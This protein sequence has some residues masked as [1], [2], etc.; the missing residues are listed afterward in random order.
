MKSAKPVVRRMLRFPADVLA[1]SSTSLKNLMQEHAYLP[2]RFFPHE[3]DSASYMITPSSDTD[4]ERSTDGLPI[5]PKN[6]WLGLYRETNEYFLHSGNVH[7]TKML[8]CLKSCGHG[9]QDGQRILELGCRSGRMIRWLFQYAT[10]GEIWGADISAD[11]ILW[12]QQYLSPPF[13]FV[14][15]TTAPHLP[16]EDNYFDL[17][18]CGSVFTHIADLAD[19]WLLELRRIVKSG[20]HLYI[21]VHDK[22]TAALIMNDPQ[23]IYDTGAT[24]N[25]W[26]RNLLL[27]FDKEQHFVGKNYNMFTI[28]RGPDSQVFYDVDYLRRHWG[29]MMKV[30][31]VKQEAFG[32][33][34]A[35]VLQK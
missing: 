13:H 35:L 23:K 31:T 32:Y 6:L 2:G 12:C 11:H 1:A 15:V 33:Q 14:T 7:V 28:S 26:T 9:V 29:G 21:T 30:L 4:V 22:H 5:P 3:P 18:Y 8:Q 24:V 20:G 16:F 10:I 25:E 27:S 19:A 17:I 34:T